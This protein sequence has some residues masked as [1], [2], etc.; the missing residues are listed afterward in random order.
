MSGCQQWQITKT[1][2][3]W[4]SIYYQSPTN[5]AATLGFDVAAVCALNLKLSA[6]PWKAHYSGTSFASC[7]LAPRSPCQLFSPHRSP[8]D[9]ITVT[10]GPHYKNS[11]VG[12]PENTKENTR[13]TDTKSKN[14]GKQTMPRVEQW[15]FAEMELTYAMEFP[16]LVNNPY[17]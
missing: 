17:P 12:V 2:G 1:L 14:I 7:L 10:C 3:H 16:Y 6:F 15:L 9:S 13:Q 8:D 11:C 4:P 5:M